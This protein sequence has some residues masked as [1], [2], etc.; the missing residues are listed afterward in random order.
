VLR[1][2][3]R[4]VPLVCV[5]RSPVCLGVAQDRTDRVEL[6]LAE[7]VGIALAALVDPR[8]EGLKATAP[9]GKAGPRQVDHQGRLRHDRHVR[10]RPSREIEDRRLPRDQTAAGTGEHVRDADEAR[11]ADVGTVRIDPPL[12]LR[13]WVET[14][15]L[16]DIHRRVGALRDLREPH[17]R[18]GVHHARVDREPCRVNCLRARWNADV[19][20]D[21]LNAAIG[22]DDDGAA[23]DLGAGDRDDAGVAD[24]VSAPGTWC[25]VERP[26][27]RVEFP[28]PN[29]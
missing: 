14:P 29:S 3:Q 11:H 9:E 2:R 16:R 1:T 26:E 12:C 4:P 6:A 24:G 13:I 27:L 22:A 7:P 20:T 18:P 15:D 10:C 28:V 8:H 19:G 23:R 25:G 5:D 17:A 21:R